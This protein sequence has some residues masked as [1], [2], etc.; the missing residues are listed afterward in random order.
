V[1][2]TVEAR[3][4]RRTLVGEMVWDLEE[5]AAVRRDHGPQAALDHVAHRAAHRHRPPG[6]RHDPGRSSGRRVEPARP[7]F[8]RPCHGTLLDPPELPDVDW[9]AED[10]ADDDAFPLTPAQRDQLIVAAKDDGFRVGLNRDGY[11]VMHR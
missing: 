9:I 4:P 3:G 6:P 7:A 10:S 2:G 11:L 8:D 1:R 5:L